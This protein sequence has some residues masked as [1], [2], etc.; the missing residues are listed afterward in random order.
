MKDIQKDRNENN[1][2]IITNNKYDIN[3]KIDKCIICNNKII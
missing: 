3:K 1:N 2:T